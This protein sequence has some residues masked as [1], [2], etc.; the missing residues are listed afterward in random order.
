VEGG[1]LDAQ[2]DRFGEVVLE[3]RAEW[4][5]QISKRC[6]KIVTAGGM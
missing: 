2:Q 6:A 3:N 4:K 5:Q 1:T